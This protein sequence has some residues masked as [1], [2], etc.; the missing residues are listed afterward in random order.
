[1]EWNEIVQTIY[2]IF[3]RISD[4]FLTFLYNIKDEL[5]W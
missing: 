5:G 2:L 1:M 3:S 4:G